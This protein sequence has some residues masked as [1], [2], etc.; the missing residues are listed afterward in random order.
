MCP[1][2]HP[3]KGCESHLLISEPIFVARGRRVFAWPGPSYRP[4]T[5]FEVELA[6]IP[7]CELNENR[8]TLPRKPL[9]PIPKRVT[10]TAWNSESPLCPDSRSGA[11]WTRHFVFLRVLLL[12]CVCL[13]LVPCS[14]SWPQI[15]YVAKGDSEFLIFLPAAPEC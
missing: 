3:D 14:P 10:A 6:K 2:P 8:G 4:T 13:V 5:W 15:H 9:V 7:G 12:P 1:P 11:T